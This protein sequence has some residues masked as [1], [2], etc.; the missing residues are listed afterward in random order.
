VTVIREVA[1]A[2]MCQTYSGLFL[3]AVNPYRDLDIYT[4][5]LAAGAPSPVMRICSNLT[6]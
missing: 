4:P 3:V 6:F 2:S 1:D 5:A